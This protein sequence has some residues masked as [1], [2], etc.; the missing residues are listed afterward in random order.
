METKSSIFKGCAL[1][2]IPDVLINLYDRHWKKRTSPSDQNNI[3]D[4][5]SITEAV[6]D[7][8]RQIQVV[9]KRFAILEDIHR[10]KSLSKNY[11]IMTFAENKF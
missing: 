11:H 10:N 6:L 3:A 7:L 4:R 1:I 9:N 8:S 2:Q 5:S